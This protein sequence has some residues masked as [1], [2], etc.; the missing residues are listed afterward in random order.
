MYQFW[1]TIHNFWPQIGFPLKSCYTFDIVVV[2]SEL[3]FEMYKHCAVSKNCH[4]FR[5]HTSKVD[6]LGMLPLFV[7]LHQA[8]N[9]DQLQTFLFIYIKVIVLDLKTCSCPMLQY[10]GTLFWNDIIIF[11]F[12]WKLRNNLLIGPKQVFSS[13]L[14][15]IIDFHPKPSYQRTW[16]SLTFSKN[17]IN[18]NNFINKLW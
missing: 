17:E 11:F 15:M 14:K 3:K 5:Q 10:F 7:L 12:K 18:W 4:W 6:L 8:W 2:I 1:I 9:Q 16:T 13:H